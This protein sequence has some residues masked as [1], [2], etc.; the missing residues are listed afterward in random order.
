[1]MRNQGNFLCFVG[2]CAMLMTSLKTPIWI[3]ATSRITAAWPIYKIAAKPLSI[4]TV[5]I[6]LIHQLRHFSLVGKST[7]KGP[8]E[9]VDGECGNENKALLFS[10]TSASD[11]ASSSCSEPL[12]FLWRVPFCCPEFVLDGRLVS[13]LEAWR[14]F[15][16]DDASFSMSGASSLL[17]LWMER[18]RRI[19]IVDLPS[20]YL[21]RS[22]F[23]RSFCQ[24]RGSRARARIKPL[25]RMFFSQITCTP[26]GYF[27]LRQ[28]Q[29]I[30]NHSISCFR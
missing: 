25:F 5:H 30:S 17:S 24:L 14:L 1:M 22:F 7:S 29:R 15:G 12:F 2:T 10:P 9:V 26:P 20:S 16:R 19:G 8:R 3:P 18:V 27:T 4:N 6:V 13:S 21:S 28:C 23:R 11:V